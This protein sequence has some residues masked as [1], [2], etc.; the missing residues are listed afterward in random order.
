MSGRMGTAGRLIRIVV[1]VVALWLGLTHRVVG[2]G[3]WAYLAD[4]V[5]LFALATGF[6]GRCPRDVL[7]GARTTRS[8]V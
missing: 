1:G 2:A 4:A 7:R 3:G 8:H 6:S 5:G